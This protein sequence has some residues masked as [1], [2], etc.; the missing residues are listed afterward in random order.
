MK[1][2]VIVLIWNVRSDRIWTNLPIQRFEK[3]LKIRKTQKN[4]KIHK[5]DKLFQNSENVGK[6]KN[7]K[8]S[9]EPKKF[10][11]SKTVKKPEK[12]CKDPKKK[13]IRKMLKDQ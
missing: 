8:I 6:H 10:E 11:N 12:L 13:T 2:H 4:P 5:T 9:E 3:N 7:P 1:I